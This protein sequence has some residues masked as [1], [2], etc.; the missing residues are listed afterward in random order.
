MTFP[1]KLV[2]DLAT[3]DGCK[4]ELTWVVVVSEDSL[5]AKDGHLS[6]KYPGSIMAG[7]RTRARESR[8]RRPT[9]RSPSHQPQAPIDVQ[10]QCQGKH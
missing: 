6:Q 9:T 7:S 8:V 1:L 4:A 3:P 10:S 2:L 5:P